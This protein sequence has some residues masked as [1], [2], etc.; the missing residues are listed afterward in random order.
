MKKWCILLLFIIIINS[1][2][3]SAFANAVGSAEVN[4]S[5]GVGGWCIVV[6]SAMTVTCFSE[7]VVGLAFGID[8]RNT[9][10]IVVTNIISQALMW[11]LYYLAAVK[12]NLGHIAVIAILE[13][14]IYIGESLVYC[15]KMRE[16]SRWK[17]LAYTVTANTVSL[18]LG[19]RFL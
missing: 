13:I 8:Y 15:K 4:G 9:P 7:W 5:A 10:L 1:M 3:V 2:T 14:V 11:G 18:I 16:V 19:V 12:W 17:C 6:T